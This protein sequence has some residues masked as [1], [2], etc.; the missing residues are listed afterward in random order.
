MNTALVNKDT[1]I[2]SSAWFD[3][4]ER[5]SEEESNL[6]IIILDTNY[7]DRAVYI[8]ELLFFVHKDEND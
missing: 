4:Y 8:K 5:V 7:F 1:F 3:E 2:N 6:I